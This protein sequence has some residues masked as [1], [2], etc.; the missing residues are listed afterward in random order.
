MVMKYLEKKV[1]KNL[2]L[3]PLA[4][5]WVSSQNASLEAWTQTEKLKTIRISYIKKHHKKSDFELKQTYQIKPS[6]VARLVG[7]TRATLMHTSSYS[8]NFSGYIV[9]INLELAELKDSQI[10]QAGK[11]SPR[12]SIRSNKEDLLKANVELRKALLELE[13]RNT[14]ALVRHAFEQLPLPIRR[15]LGIE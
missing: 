7:I 13:R 6:E 1:L 15:K 10:A 8:K 4:P 11:S 9:A 3:E 12:G 5:S 2:E 14:E